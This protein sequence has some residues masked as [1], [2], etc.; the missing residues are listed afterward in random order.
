[1]YFPPTEDDSDS[2]HV[3]KLCVRF[4]H[5]FAQYL[6]KTSQIEAIRCSHQFTNF[7]YLFE[8]QDL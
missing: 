8:T 3:E 7:S 6:L 2:Q 1:M 5:T 4:L